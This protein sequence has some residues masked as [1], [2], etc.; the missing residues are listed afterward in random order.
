M[1]RGAL[2]GIARLGRVAIVGYASGSFLTLDPLDMVLRNYTA[3]GVFAGGAP[4]EDAAAYDDL[5]HLAEA[6]RITTPLTRVVGFDDVPKTLAKPARA[7][8]SC[9]SRLAER[10][11]R[12]DG[13]D[14][15]PLLPGWVAGSSPRRNTYSCHE[16]WAECPCGW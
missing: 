8:P 3:V 9:A 13:L 11:R 6:G 4:A 10:T 2:A 7:S 12:S 1:W 14:S 5:H 16:H 15:A